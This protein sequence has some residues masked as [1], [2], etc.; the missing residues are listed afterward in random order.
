MQGRITED[1]STK[2][3]FVLFLLF[4]LAF[5]FGLA[6]QT[7]AAQQI[8]SIRIT[9]QIGALIPGAQVTVLSP[10]GV[11]ALPLTADANGAAQ[12]PCRA[13]T[14]LHL[15]ALGFAPRTAVLNACAGD[16]EYRLAPATVQATVNIVVTPDEM[17]NESI[18][19]SEQISRTTARTVFDAVDDLSPAVFVTRRGV[20][21]Y[22][23]STNGTGQ[24]SIRGVGGSPNTDILVVI[25]GR[26]DYQGEMGHTLPDFY[27]LSDTGSIRL[28]EGPASVLY[29]SNA[30]GG[31]VEILPRLP[32]RG[33]EFELQSQLG[34]FVTGQHRLYAG[35]RQGRGTYTFSAGVNHTDGDRPYSAYHSQD[36]SVGTEYQL[37]SIWKASL[38]GNYGH[39]LV[40]DPG[41]INTGFLKQNTASVGR[42]GVTADMGNSTPALNGYTRFYSTWGHNATADRWDTN[43]NFDSTDRIT[44]GRLFQTWTPQPGRTQNA[45]A[46][47]FGGDFVNY[48]G[49]AENFNVARTS[50]K[51]YGGPHQIY[52]DAGFVRAHWSP[53]AKTLLNA[54]FRYQQNSTFGG[55]PV[56]EFGAQWHA[57]SRY[58]FSTSISRGFRNPSIRELYLFP[59]PNPN[60]L[61]V[62]EWSYEATAQAR[63]TQNIAAWTTFYYASLTNQ[64]VTL[65]SYPNMQMLNGGKAINKGVEAKLRWSGIGSAARRRLSLTTGYAYLA[66]T[67]IAPLVPANKATLGLDLD[68]KRAFLHMDVQAIG[69]RYTDTTHTTQLG[70]YTA[71]SLKLSI[72]VRRNLN[73][74]AT[75]DNLL[76][77][78]YQ[79]LTGYPMPGINGA[80]GFVLH[81]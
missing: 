33:V 63:L 61:P 31:A 8:A 21:G 75:A 69:K 44:G 56:P 66:S 22:G 17:P 72:P 27:S 49:A 7:G 38:H 46:F 40:Q 65:G 81:F 51:L 39:F 6:A 76:N 36:G 30:M 32:K 73:L 57:S 54:G 71:T 4:I 37:N 52:D 11:G 70:G 26:P 47:D 1:G 53:S 42:G 55:I 15:T 68:M 45:L 28:I 2:R 77:H 25:D 41:V 35:L 5:P 10:D 18:T 19:T 79:V 50:V 74:F 67:N 43:T 3:G 12:V 29:G 80:G 9:D 24:V 16:H 78:R 59:A 34:S 62:H 13:G 58:T 20:M 48:G 14:I 23:I 60:L 64:I